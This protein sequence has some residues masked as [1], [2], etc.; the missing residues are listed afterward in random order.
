MNQCYRDPMYPR[1]NLLI[2]RHFSHLTMTDN[3]LPVFVTPIRHPADQRHGLIQ[4]SRLHSFIALA[5]HY[6]LRLS[7]HSLFML[8]KLDFWLNLINVSVI[9]HV[10]L[11]TGSWTI[12]EPL[13]GDNQSL[14]TRTAFSA[15]G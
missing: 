5:N 3:I 13:I 4:S 1:G 11:F 7:M 9:V 8:Y 12:D 6:Q 2:T 14:G 10:Y 15:C